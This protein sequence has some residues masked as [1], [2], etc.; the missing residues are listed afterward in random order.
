[1][2]W[3]F[4]N[5]PVSRCSLVVL[6]ALALAFALTADAAAQQPAAKDAFGDPLPDGA[7]A[8]LGSIRWRHAGQTTFAAFLSDGKTVVSA[9]EDKTIRVWDYPSGKELR[10]IGP[11]VA[12]K[13]VKAVAAPL[14][15]LPFFPVALSKD[16]KTLAA[17][18]DIDNILVFE[19][20]TGKEL[21]KLKLGTGKLSARNLIQVLAF[22]P[23][24]QQLA[25][26]GR[27]GKGRLWDWANA[28]EMNSF[29][30]SRGNMGGTADNVALVWS[31]NGKMLAVTRE[32][33][34]NGEFFEFVD[35]WDPAMGKIV[36]TIKLTDED[37][38]ISGIVFAPDSKT[39]AMG[40]FN[41]QTTLVD[42]ATGKKIFNSKNGFG[43]A[44]LVF[45]P[46]GARLYG[47]TDRDKGLVEWD[48]ADGKTLQKIKISAAAPELGRGPA[49]NTSAAWSPDGRVL[50]LAGVGNA[51]QF[52]DVAAGKEIGT[53]VA[54]LT[55][56]HFTPD[57]KHVWSRDGNGVVQKWEAATGKQL[58]LAKPLVSGPSSPDGKLVVAPAAAGEKDSAFVDAATGKELATFPV[59]A[60]LNRAM[61]FSPNSKML[62]VRQF[63]NKRITLYEAPTGKLLRS[64][65][66]D[67][68]V[69]AGPG[70][71]K[72][73]L[74]GLVFFSPDS[75]MLLAFAD[76][77]TL[78]VWNTATG[79]R[80]AEL[81][82][83]NPFLIQSGAFSR[84]GRCVVLDFNDGR[85][86]LYELASGRERRTFGVG[87]PVRNAVRVGGGALGPV[88]PEARV[89]FGRHGQTLIRAGYDRVIHV[90]DADTGKKLAAFKGHVDSV[91]AIALSADGKTL[92]SASADATALLWD[93]TRVERTAAPVT[94]LTQ[95]ERDAHWRA[96]LDDDAGKAF[97]A[98]CALSAAPEETLALL[99]ERVKPAAP[100]DMKRAEELIADLASNQFNTR[101][102]AKAELIKMGERVAPAVDRILAGNITLEYKR[103]LDELRQQTGG[104]VLQG[105]R[106]R[107]HRAVEILERIGTAEA[108]RLLQALADGAPGAQLTTTAHAALKRMAPQK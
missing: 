32:E 77:N 17:C 40:T 14:R 87:A 21:Q 51:P 11:P 50:V 19:T 6:T 42:V 47:R 1:M 90:W 66:I 101:E 37:D 61:L 36:R 9:G 100:L 34:E 108:R 22:S 76:P 25:S 56:L 27:D 72:A 79:E 45:S 39:L 15:F 105:E 23:D 63:Q 103:R 96:L 5:L 44:P 75:M 97:A 67:T 62:A 58:D 85:T 59:P 92:A 68:L 41:G 86:I 26:M 35:I 20:A 57:A 2:S 70:G 93:L 54:P 95:S 29:A 12:D 84:D 18:F 82:A 31:P 106:L 104:I 52:V 48:A 4:K 46:D 28:K 60:K 89:V 71:G 80:V 49:R 10:R 91:D 64:L 30:G 74:P 69:A 102:Q 65:A 8:R 107:T 13:T 88:I 99:K 24:G 53:G 55:A 81:R 38:S 98:I 33:E 3:R 94:S 43:T 16:G 7:T 78:A 73:A 83:P